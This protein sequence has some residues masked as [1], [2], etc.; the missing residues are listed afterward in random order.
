MNGYRCP[1]RPVQDIP[2]PRRPNRRPIARREARRRL[3]RQEGVSPAASRPPTARGRGRRPRRSQSDHEPQTWLE[4]VPNFFRV[5]PFP[6]PASMLSRMPEL[7]GERARCRNRWCQID[8][9]GSYYLCSDHAEKKKRHQF[10]DT[11]KTQRHQFGAPVRADNARQIHVGHRLAN[12]R[13]TAWSRFSQQ[14]QQFGRVSGYRDRLTPEWDD[15]VVVR[16]GPVRKK[17]RQAANDRGAV[18]TLD[19]IELAGVKG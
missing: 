19:Q 10:G 18:R 13:E 5:E 12:Q 4:P 1:H 11:K 3:D 9:V 2:R 17:R 16:V 8:G 14:R 7:T 6:G 15:H